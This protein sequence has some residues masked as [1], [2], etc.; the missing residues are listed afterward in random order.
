MENQDTLRKCNPCPRGGRIAIEGYHGQNVLDLYANYNLIGNVAALNDLNVNLSNCCTPAL[1]TSATAAIAQLTN[2]PYFTDNVRIT[3]D[4]GVAGFEN[5]DF[6]TIQEQTTDSPNNFLQT[7]LYQFFGDPNNNHRNTKTF[8]GLTIEF[9]IDI[10]TPLDIGGGPCGFQAIITGNIFDNCV[11]AA[12]VNAPA[13]QQIA[14]FVLA[15]NYFTLDDGFPIVD[16]GNPPFNTFANSYGQPQS[17]NI[18]FAPSTAFNNGLL[19]VFGDT[20]VRLG[21]MPVFAIIPYDPSSSTTDPLAIK[22][23]Q[24]FE[25]EITMNTLTKFI[26]CDETEP[27]RIF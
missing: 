27:C 9:Q 5:D 26:T 11:K 7:A 18:S 6:T 2:A 13:M 3:N 22:L 15:S 16:L 19:F 1:K 10:K 24:H 23:V 14:Q 12:N 8:R 25:L 21:Q 20:I 17:R 4:L